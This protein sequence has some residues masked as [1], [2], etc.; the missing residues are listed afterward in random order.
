MADGEW[1][2][3]RR[4][5]PRPMPQRRDR[6]YEEFRGWKD[7]APPVSFGRRDQVPYPNPNPNP[8]PL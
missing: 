3:V 7:R 5:R 2:L 8:N 6:G 4:K 1:Q